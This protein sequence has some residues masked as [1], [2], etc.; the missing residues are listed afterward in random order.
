LLIANCQLRCSMSMSDASPPPAALTSLDVHDAVARVM[1][2]VRPLASERVPLAEAHGRVLAEPV[3]SPVAIPPWDNSSMDGYAVRGED[4]AGAC[5]DAP[6]VLRVLETVAAGGRATRR[7]GA[8]EATRIMTGAPVPDG[9][10]CVVRVEDTDGGVERVAVR[11]ARDVGRNVRRRGEDVEPGAAVLDAGTAI[12]AARLGVL[13]SVGAAQVAVHRRP[14]VAILATGDELVDL[15]GFDAVRAG[16]RIVSSNSWTLA[17]QVREAGG[18]PV[19]LG[20]ARDDRD[21]LRA[22]LERARGCDLLLTSGGVSV[23]AF[24]FTR[25]VLAS[26]GAT[27]HLWRARIRPGAPIGFGTWDGMPWLGLPGNPVSAMVTFELFARPVI[28]RLAG[29]A[30]VHRRAVPVV[31]EERVTLAAPLT[32]FLRAVVA[33]RADGTLG[34]RLTGAQSSGMLTSMARANALVVVP[35]QPLVREPGERLGA[36]LLGDGALASD[37]FDVGPRA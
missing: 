9:A 16:E 35:P 33:P 2:D 24:D 25:E 14:R 19:P 26:L 5:A 23:G 7:V 12:G 29:H 36:L 37:T 31:L 6:V 4:V 8:G 1:A 10:D 32:H 27:L 20:I 18:E 11:D 15:D 3:V 21:A 13:A 22:H 30:A 17:A 28:R 34:A